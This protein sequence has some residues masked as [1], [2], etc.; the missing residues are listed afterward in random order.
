VRG[1]A[2]L[3]N[4][5]LA[6]K[7]LDWMVCQRYSWHTIWVYKR[8]LEDFLFFW[9]RSKLSNV[10]H[11]DIRNFLI[12]MSRRDLSAD[13]AHRFLGGLRCFFD[14]LCI[15]GLVDEVAPR[16]IRPRPSKRSIPRSLSEKN[17]RRLIAAA[18]NPRD[19]AII[20]VFYATGCR[21]SE[22][23][24]IRLE[25]I[26]F[27]TRTIKVAGK[28][29]ERRVMFGHKAKRAMLEYLQGRQSGH[30][31]QSIAVVQQGS[32]VRSKFSWNGYWNDYTEARTIPHHRRIWLG[33]LSMSRKEAWAKF[34]KRVP[35]PD[36][37]HRR[38]KRASITRTVVSEMLKV[39]AF[40]I[41][42]GKI[43]CHTLR[44]SFATHLLDHGADVRVVQALLGHSSLATTENYCHVSAARLAPCY[45]RSHPRS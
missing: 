16:L 7:F 36:A 39:A 18:R 27:K 4:D 6:S 14:F 15:R 19:K 3:R 43:S 13:I 22:L 34:R 35:N 41:G 45:N 33:N 9:G 28:G 29:S 8:V 24:N 44:H 26:D 31:F 37:G 21:A 2:D 10:T 5:Q 42:L 1:L 11:L 40:R 12:E 25:Q 20:E 30:L 32:V 38:V 23:V 17:V